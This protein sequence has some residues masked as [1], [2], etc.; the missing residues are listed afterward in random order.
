MAGLTD[1][2]GAGE[3]DGGAEGL[4]IGADEPVRADAPG[5]AGGAAP[6]N[7]TTTTS[8][9]SARAASTVVRPI[10]D[11]VGPRP[12]RAVAG[13]AGAEAVSTGR[14]VVAWTG[15][16]ILVVAS[17][18]S[19]ISAGSPARGRPTATNDGLSTGTPGAAAAE[20][21]TILLHELAHLGRWDDWTNL[22]QKVLGALLFFHP[23]V[24][25]IKKAGP[26]TRDGVR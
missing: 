7:R 18:A 9:T 2:D 4:A 8:A 22:A 23:A 3:A 24:W 11:V 10:Q 5:T 6:S 1:A 16:S 25:W 21:N 13:A 12:V 26:G 20:L 15:I 14:T 19:S 17:S